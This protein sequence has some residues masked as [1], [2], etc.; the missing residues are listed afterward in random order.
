MEDGGRA[1][2]GIMQGN[3]FGDILGGAFSD[4]FKGLISGGILGGILGGVDAAFRNKNIWTGD[5]K[6]RYYEPEFYASSNS[7][8]TEPEYPWKAT[9]V[10]KDQYPVFYK[11]EDGVYGISQ[12]VPAYKGYGKI[13]YITDR[14]DGVATSLYE[15]MVYKVPGKWWS[16]RSQVIVEQGGKINGIDMPI[17]IGIGKSSREW[18]NGS[19]SWGWLRRSDFP[20][21]DL[22]GSNGFDGW[23]LLFKFSTMIKR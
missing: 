8:Y 23:E 13:P 9:V 10:N 4:G 16:V 17:F 18:I 5:A 3:S 2:N 20:A 7:S 11:P 14:V 6:I 1:G 19:A 12:R 15:N 21:V 22:F